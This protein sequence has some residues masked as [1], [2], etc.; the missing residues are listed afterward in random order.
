MR[1][2][3][4]RRLS[5]LLVLLGCACALVDT[6]TAEL[7][8]AQSAIRDAESAGA[9]VRAPAELASARDRLARA[10]AESRKGHYDEALF[11]AEQAEADARLAAVKSR[12]ASAEAALG[13]V[14]RGQPIEVGDRPAR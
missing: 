3:M 11:L 1:Y 12:A 4:V 9:A 8:V 7:A 14:R 13:V 10:Q 5:W 6:P 2:V